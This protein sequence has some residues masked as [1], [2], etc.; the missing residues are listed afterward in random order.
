MEGRTRL[1]SFGTEDRMNGFN[2]FIQWKVFANAFFSSCVESSL[3]DVLVC[4]CGEHD[5]AGLSVVSGF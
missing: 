1:G 3:N 5:N 2:N 4:G